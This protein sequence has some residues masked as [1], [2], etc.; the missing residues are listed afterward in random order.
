MRLAAASARRGPRVACRHQDSSHERPLP[1]PD[2]HRRVRP[3]RR[4]SARICRGRP[5][6]TDLA[7]AHARAGVGTLCLADA[8]A[9]RLPAAPAAA[10]GRTLR[11]RGA[12]WQ[13]DLGHA[14]ELRSRAGTAARAG[15][16]GARADAPAPAPDPPPHPAAPAGAADRRPHGAAR[17]RCRGAVARA[18][19]Q[20]ALPGATG[21]RGGLQRP[22]HCA[23]GHRG[24]VVLLRAV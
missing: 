20:P 24:R 1:A 12:Q 17:W 2:G 15:A 10:G 3:G 6:A 4:R 13:P 22:H 5:G 21:G 16:P 18:P 11:D 19:S 7:D 23:G 8:A 14:A 9:G